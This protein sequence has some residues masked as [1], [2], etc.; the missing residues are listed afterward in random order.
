MVD[1]IEFGSNASYVEKIYRAWVE[2]KTSCSLEWSSIF[3]KPTSP[4]KRLASI[5]SGASELQEKAT[6]LVR[7]YREYGFASAK[8]DPLNRKHEVASC[9]EY[10]DLARYGFLSY[11]MGQEVLC[12]GFKGAKSFRLS[13]LIKELKRVYSGSV[14]FEFFHVSDPKKRKWLQENLERQATERG[15]YGFEEQHGFL[16][17]LIETE[18]F[19]SEIHLKY[20]STKAFSLRGAETVNVMLN[21]LTDHVATLGIG[22]VSICMGRRGRLS[23]LAGVAGKP[24]R[25]IL[26]EL[27]SR[28]AGISC[29]IIEGPFS[30]AS[31]ETD[32]EK[33]EKL[34]S[35]TVCPPPEDNSSIEETKENVSVIVH[36][37]IFSKGSAGSTMLCRESTEPS[38]GRIHLVINDRGGVGVSEDAKPLSVSLF[39][40]AK[41]AQIPIFH[42]NCEDIDSSVWLMGLAYDYRQ[43]FHSDIMIDL[44]CYRAFG[45]ESNVGSE[46]AQSEM[47]AVRARKSLAEMYSGFLI[48]EELLTEEE[49]NALEEKVV[50]RIQAQ[51]PKCK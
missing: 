24:L 2:R 34:V 18:F 15:S 48:Q 39:D 16:E 13:D 43:N 26:E 47:L 41:I 38:E 17:K 20:P 31:V 1:L 45:E 36:E 33:R 9:S 14:G 29:E 42:V 49:K 46:D 35:I 10:L 50:R 28:D 27:K 19:E 23:V 11:E 5:E 22:K 4:P 25:E 30:E 21:A 6:L 44:C 40:Y 3:G 32:G 51:M 12:D 37:D 7:A 8:L